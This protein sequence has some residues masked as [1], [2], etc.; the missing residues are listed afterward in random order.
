MSEQFCVGHWT[1]GYCATNRSYNKVSSGHSKPVMRI[2]N[3]T[4]YRT[5][6]LRELFSAA[7]CLIGDISRVWYITIGYR[8]SKK[9]GNCHGWAYLNTGR[10]HISLPHRPSSIKMKELCQITQHEIDHCLGLNHSE[11][12]DWW[13]LKITWSKDLGKP[14][15]N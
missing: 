8:Y 13:D 12:L 15:K 3:S 11:M 9:I 7:I 10:F 14:R 1:P 6:D 4:D 5:D 2:Y